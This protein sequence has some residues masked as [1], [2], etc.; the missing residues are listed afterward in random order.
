MEQTAAIN[1][2]GDFRSEALLASGQFCQS[3]GMRSQPRDLTQM[4]TSLCLP[5][6]DN[7]TAVLQAIRRKVIVGHLTMLALLICGAAMLV[8]AVKGPFVT[9]LG[10]LHL[11]IWAGI[12]I[13]I[14]GWVMMCCSVNTEQWIIRRHLAARGADQ[15]PF[16]PT[17]NPLMFR[18]EDPA[19]YKVIKVVI[20]DVA[21]A[22]CDAARGV[23]QL[24]GFAYRYVIWAKDIQ[25]LNRL[26]DRFVEVTFC[27]GG[28]DQMLALAIAMNGVA[29]ELKKQLSFGMVKRAVEAP[30]KRVFGLPIPWDVMLDSGALTL[31]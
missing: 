12:T 24:E 15:A 28:S 31:E 10:N 23:I 29:I 8:I 20:D 5:A 18:M 11:P 3:A 21:I 27:V 4:G 16:P 6:S 14:A 17:E 9:P 30:L 26:G 19:T 2:E 7:P 25:S 1:Y 22:W 13:V